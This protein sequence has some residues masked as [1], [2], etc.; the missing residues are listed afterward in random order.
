MFSFVSKITCRGMFGFL[1]AFE[2]GPARLKTQQFLAHG[3]AA[4]IRRR[5]TKGTRPGRISRVRQNSEKTFLGRGD[6]AMRTSIC[7]LF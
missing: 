2:A 3:R 7:H 4:F 1:L 6:M 5:K